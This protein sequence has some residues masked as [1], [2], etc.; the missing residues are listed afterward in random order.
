LDLDKFKDYNDQYGHL[1]GDK[2]LFKSGKIILSNIRENVDTAF[3]YGGDE[4]AVI[5]VEADEIIARRIRERVEWGFEQGGGVRASV[6]LAIYS[7]EM[8][9]NDLIALAD[10]KLYQVKNKTGLKNPKV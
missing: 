1:A 6:G 3:R 5:L 4:F 10:K 2:M 8:D 7:K 9:V